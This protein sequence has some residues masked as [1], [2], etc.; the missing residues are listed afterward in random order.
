M[1]TKKQTEKKTNDLYEHLSGAV[2]DM[3]GFE[4]MTQ[5]TQAVPFIK[6]LQEMSP[7]ARMKHEQYKEGAAPG[8]LYNTVNDNLYEP[9]LRFVVGKFEHLYVEY[10]PKRGGFVGTW[11]VQ[12][13]EKQPLEWAVNEEGAR[14]LVH[15]VTRNNFVETYSYYC[16]LPDYLEEGVVIFSFYS[17]ALKEA[18][19]LNRLLRSTP[20]PHSAKKALPYFMIWQYGVAERKK[21]ADTWL[22]PSFKFDSFVTQSQLEYVVE[23]RKTLPNKTVDYTQLALPDSSTTGTEEVDET[24]KVLY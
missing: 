8:L 13:A 19:R 16:L 17:T 3:S 23:E 10:L 20:L 12:D 18:K 7:E 11:S 14:K 2:D 1:A 4:E 5:D 6:L 9:P 15:R 24:G 21:D 22:V